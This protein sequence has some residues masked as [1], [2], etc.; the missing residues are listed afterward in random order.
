MSKRVLMLSW[1]YPPRIIGGLARVV[2]QLSWKMAKQGWEV[3]VVT[4]D[5]PGS[6]EHEIEHGVHVHR[7][8][9]QTDPTPDFLTWVHRLNFGLLQYAIELHR[10]TPFDIVH[11][12]DW[13]VCDAAWVMKKGFGV[14][15]VATMH[16][17][18][19]GRMKGIHTDLQRYIN[20]MEW[21]LTFEAWKVIVNSQHMQQELQNQFKMPQDKI[22]VIPNGIDPEVFDF[23]FDARPLRNQFASE[24][25]KIVLFV[26]RMVL[27]K[28]VQVLLHA[29]PS[30]EYECPGTKFLFVGTGYYLDELKATAENLGIGHDCKFLGYVSDPDLL[31]LYKIADAV[32]I[33]S[34]YEP[35]GI[36]ALEGMAA[37]V[38]V[39]TSDTGGLPDF[40]EN[41]A[42]GVTTYTGNTQ[43]LSW[44][45]L[46]VLRNPELAESLKEE[47]YKRVT[48]IY[49]WK[50]IAAHT[51]EV[52]EEVLAQAGQMGAD[53]VASTPKQPLGK[54]AAAKSS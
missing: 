17:T 15:M 8:K 9:T 48:N 51:L 6:P 31:K 35:F 14:P 40:V 10:K 1:E 26:G 3:H 25:E 50:M 38:P 20:Q 39:V 43:S 41:M 47:G 7:V 21:R 2:A 52:Y 54:A 37:K 32:C 24:H 33:P 42:N 28:G 36:V 46:Q 30:V 34:L 12:H 45:L 19:A 13:M 44:G 27:E 5:H 22:T 16:A 18:E 29:V 23:E 11:A 49:N 53:G 4:A